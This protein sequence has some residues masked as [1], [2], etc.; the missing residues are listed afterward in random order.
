MPDQGGMTV[1]E[2]VDY[3]KMKKKKGIYQEYEEI[4]KEPP[5]G[6]FDYSK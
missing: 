5:A 3:V 2:L 6:T 4:R 1:H